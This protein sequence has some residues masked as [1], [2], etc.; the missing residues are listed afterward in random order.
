M[1]ERRSLV[2]FLLYAL[3]MFIHVVM[4]LMILSLFLSFSLSSET[5]SGDFCIPNFRWPSS[6][7]G[8]S[9]KDFSLFHPFSLH[10]SFLLITPSLTPSPS[11]TNSFLHA[12][13]SPSPPPQHAGLVYRRDRFFWTQ[14]LVRFKGNTL[15]LFSS[16]GDG[17]HFV[18]S[19]AN[20]RKY[21]IV[22]A[23]KRLRKP[24][25]MEVGRG[26][27]KGERREERER[28]RGRRSGLDRVGW[29]CGEI[30]ERREEC[31]KRVI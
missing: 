21:T 7:Q 29:G 3:H 10:F 23:E 11:L 22:C 4:Y 12:N 27:E 14:Y 26:E 8:I 16:E 17:S 15:F 13:S 24:L 9:F 19:I 1:K 25:C 18:D 28:E 2:A 20:V 6:C 31:V 5:S 30:K